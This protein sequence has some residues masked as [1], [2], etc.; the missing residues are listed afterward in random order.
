MFP[1]SLYPTQI[2]ILAKMKFFN[3]HLFKDETIRITLAFSRQYRIYSNK[4]LT[5]NVVRRKLWFISMF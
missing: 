5:D 4:S 1:L 2:Y 3:N